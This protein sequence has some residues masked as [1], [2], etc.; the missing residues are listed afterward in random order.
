[1]TILTYNAQNLFDDVSNE[2]DYPEYNP[3]NGQ[4][5][6]DLYRERLARTAAVIRE[7]VRGGPDIVA[8]Q[9]IENQQVLDALVSRQLA[10]LGYLHT[11]LVRSIDSAVNVGIITRLPVLCATAYPVTD[12]FDP[13]PTRDILQIAI[14]CSGTRLYLL[15]CHWKSQSGGTQYTEPLRLRAAAV[16]HDR[17]E[18]IL[19]ENVHAEVLVLGDLNESVDEWQRT[20]M[21]YQ[22]ALVLCNSSL[23]APSGS[24]A[25]SVD[26]AATRAS[27][28]GGM[29]FSPW[30]KAGTSA[31]TSGSYWYN[32]SWE[33]YDNFLLS[34]GLLDPEGLSFL[35]FWV[36]PHD[37]LRDRGGHPFGWQLDTGLGYSDHFPLLLVLANSD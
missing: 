4:W 33:T 28:D 6:S 16:V 25:V 13:V 7:S 37:Y 8:L 19:A 10:D 36:V 31:G 20:G 15:V 21:Q 29:L 23:D 35:D 30:G 32:G 2:S 34:A 9:E 22:T 1:M 18:A 24:L 11:V 5:T 14:D 3:E 12:C 27:R 26:L 17:L